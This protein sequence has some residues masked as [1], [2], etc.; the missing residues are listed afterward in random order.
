MS[1]IAKLQD[2]LTGALIGLARAAEGN[3]TAPS[4][5]RAMIEGLIATI[6]GE[7]VSEETLR[8]HIEIVMK[9]KY[10]LIPSCKECASPCGRT[11]NYNIKQLQ[12]ADENVRSLKNTLL[13][14]LRQMAVNAGHA[15]KLGYTDDTV[16]A[17]F[18]EGLFIVGENWSRDDLMPVIQKFEAINLKCKALLNKAQTETGDNVQL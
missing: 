10:T 18:Y 15:M 16:N 13:S 5:H 4:T 12:E 7:I 6:T 8:N 17:F 3:I 11:D 14:G 1:D 9:E 2:E